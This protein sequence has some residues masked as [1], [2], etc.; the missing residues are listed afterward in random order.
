ML[1][2]TSGDPNGQ[3]QRIQKVG[4]GHDGVVAPVGY[5]VVEV[6]TE[7]CAEIRDLVSYRRDLELARSY[8][9]TFVA[10]KADERGTDRLNDALVIAALTLYGRVF[11]NGVRRARVS[12]DGLNGNQQAAHDYFIH[13]RNKYVAHAVNGY[14]Q[15]TVIAYL[16]D[17]P[18]ARP[19][20]TRV[21]QRH[22]D[23]V[24][25][26]HSE[27]GDFVDLCNLHVE[28][29]RERH[30]KLIHAVYQELWKMGKDAVYALPDL[31]APAGLRRSDVGARRS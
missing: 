12:L 20:V 24:A 23:I 28:G 4:K 9:A 5:R 30:K 29:I 7:S 6:D 10:S 21:G 26:D 2:D 13:L 22:I 18:R 11:A 8:M 17:S 3:H 31:V 15:T 19:E 14:E 27:G 1:E 25:L 16:T